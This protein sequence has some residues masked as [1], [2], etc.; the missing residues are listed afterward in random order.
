MTK[1]PFQSAVVL[2][3]LVLLSPVLSIGA[4]APYSLRAED[5]PVYRYEVK[6]VIRQLPDSPREEIFIRHEPIPD[7][8]NAQGEKVG[9]HAMTMPFWVAEGVSLD[10]FAVGDTVAF[11][12]ESRWKP[13]ASDKI[14]KL[15]KISAAVA[16]AEAKE[17]EGSHGAHDH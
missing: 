3:S 6:G 15:E 10:G 12:L 16:S 17:E 1:S 5:A 14:T 11:S 8:V 7:Y 4:F 2:L 13:K 9:M